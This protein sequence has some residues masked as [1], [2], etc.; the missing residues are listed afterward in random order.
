MNKIDY[1][2]IID[3]EIGPGIGTKK[4]YEEIPGDS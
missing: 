4:Q 3:Q 2:V 1:H